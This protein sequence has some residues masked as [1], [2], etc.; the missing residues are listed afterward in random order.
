MSTQAQIPT[1]AHADSRAFA[2]RLALFY[3]TL[4]GLVGT[5]LPFFPVWLKAVGIEPVWI[6]I[7]TALPA[8]SRFT[9]LP[10][11][12]SLAER[13]QAVRRFRFQ[14]FARLQIVHRL[15]IICGDRG[16]DLMRRYAGR[17]LRT[18]SL[19]AIHGSLDDSRF[20]TIEDQT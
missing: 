13:R 10:F 14:P 8:L 9:V 11:V 5:H 20:G 17:R 16:I 1:G 19:F 12:T 3:G 6:G 15:A 18:P 4:F 7:I 2:T